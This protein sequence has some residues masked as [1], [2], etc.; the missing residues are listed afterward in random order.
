MDRSI[1]VVKDLVL[2]AVGLGGIIYQ[3]LTG[4]VNIWLLMVFVTMTGMPGLTSLLALFKSGLP[5]GSQLPSAP[6]TASDSD[7]PR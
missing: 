2:F 6:P 5:T 7:S 4:N 1:T 3:L